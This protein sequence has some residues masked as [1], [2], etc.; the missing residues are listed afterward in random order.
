MTTTNTPNTPIPSDWISCD[1]CGRAIPPD[2]IHT[3][4]EDETICADCAAPG[5][6]P[7]A[8]ADVIVFD[9]DE[10]ESK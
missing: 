2:Q 9:E 7:F 5:S 10:E 3:N 1:I 8:L 6:V 4:D